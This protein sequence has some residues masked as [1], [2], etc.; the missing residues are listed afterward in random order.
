M[1]DD[2]WAPFGQAYD[3]CDR[4]CERCALAP[5][6]PVAVRDRGRRWAHEMRGRDPDDWDVVMAD[7]ADDMATIMKELDAIEAEEDEEDEEEREAP[8]PPAV[9][10]L[11]ERRL[12]QLSEELVR[13]VRESGSKDALFGA[14]LILSMKVARIGG[15]ARMGAPEDDLWEPDIAPN[16]LL[17]ERLCRALEA[18]LE[19]LPELEEPRRALAALE[20]VLAPLLARAE[21]LRAHLDALIAAGNAPSPFVTAEREEAG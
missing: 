13:A 17:I 12:E 4:R 20:R 14:V 2:A 19:A 11:T 5:S 18:E 16:V 10:S 21:P 3:W 15:L 9:I 8:P 6:C 1:A 7:V